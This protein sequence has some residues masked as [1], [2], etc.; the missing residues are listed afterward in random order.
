MITAGQGA[1][2]GRIPKI[3]KFK[4]L[5]KTVHMRPKMQRTDEMEEPKSTD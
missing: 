4:S 1:D 3:K 2:Q 5:Q